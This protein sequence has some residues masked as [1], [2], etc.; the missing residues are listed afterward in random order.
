[1]MAQEVML[2]DQGVN[3]APLINARHFLTRSSTHTIVD[4]NWEIQSRLK[5]LNAEWEFCSEAYLAVWL[6]IN[7]RAFV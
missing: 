3:A 7:S 4:A 1:M 5:A 6:S 2:E